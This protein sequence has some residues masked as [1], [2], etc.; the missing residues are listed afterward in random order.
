MKTFSLVTILTLSTAAFGQTDSVTLHRKTSGFEDLKILTYNVGLLSAHLYGDIVPLVKERARLLPKVL[1]PF[2]EK[3]KVDLVLLQE[4]W[5]DRH[6]D[7]LVKLFS[8]A[9]YQT[10][11]PKQ[12]PLLLGR[13]LQYGSGLMLT[14]PS[15]VKIHR[16][17]FYPFDTHAGWAASLARQGI[18][19]AKL[20]GPAKIPFI[21]LG[22]HMQAFDTQGGT[23]VDP[24]ELAA[25]QDQA[26]QINA[27]LKQWSL[28]GKYP[29]ILL[30]DFNIGPG[31]VDLEY[32][33]FLAPNFRMK[34]LMTRST[35]ISW[36]KNNYLVR[37]GTYPNEHLL[38]DHIFVRDSLHHL[39]RWTPLGARIVF[40]ETYPISVT[41]CY[42]G[43]MAPGM[44]V[45]IHYTTPLSDH[46]G[47]LGRA[48][49]QRSTP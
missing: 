23:R 8:T 28:N 47:V 29:V 36:D 22:V 11:C 46:Y 5:D 45:T 12:K 48:R 14:V 19:A 39:G 25:F 9:G 34:N 4:V 21:V 15:N 38:A 44:P 26:R 13:H 7:A 18:L 20:E 24:A 17:D 30:G 32:R 42:S 35:A 37:H 27:T 2:L 3:E 33:R 31:Y 43:G 16:W 10:R 40:K 41:L 6:R 1:K 49:I